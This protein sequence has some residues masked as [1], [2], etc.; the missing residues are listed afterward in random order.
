M[1]SYDGPLRALN[2]QLEVDFRANCHDL[3]F[4]LSMDLVIHKPRFF[5]VL[6]VSPLLLGVFFGTFEAERL[7][8]QLCANAS[9]L[10]ECIAFLRCDL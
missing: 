8:C 2:L 9:Q 1:L 10:N 3:F 7:D 4:G 5:F 6:C